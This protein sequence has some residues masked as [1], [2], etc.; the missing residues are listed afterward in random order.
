M[1]KRK[2]LSEDS[3]TGIN[4]GVVVELTDEELNK[5]PFNVKLR[6]LKPIDDKEK[7]ARAEKKKDEDELRHVLSHRGLSVKRSALVVV[8][9]GSLKNLQENANKAGIDELTDE[10]LKKEFGSKTK[11]APGGDPEKRTKKRKESDK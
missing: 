1:V 4:E 7:L 2:Y 10:W 9:Y 11:A 5:V 6:L 8:K 3:R